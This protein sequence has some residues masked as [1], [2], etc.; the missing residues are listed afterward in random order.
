MERDLG[1]VK[2][3][4]RDGLGEPV[5]P[6]RQQGAAKEHDYQINDQRPERSHG[7]TIRFHA[8]QAKREFGDILARQRCSELLS[9]SLG[10]KP[11]AR[12]AELLV[13]RYVL[14][15]SGFCSPRCSAVAAV[16]STCEFFV[17]EGNPISSVSLD[18]KKVLFAS[19]GAMC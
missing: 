9:N 11:E 17:T 4:R 14:R 19:A 10:T 16:G 2:E 6:R 1:K 13:S 3:G 7:A 18:G 12:N 15:I 5:K 8:I